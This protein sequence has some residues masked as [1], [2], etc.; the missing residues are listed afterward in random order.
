[1]NTLNATIKMGRFFVLAGLVSLSVTSCNLLPDDEDT[2]TTAPNPPTPAFSDGYATLAAVK[3]VTFQDLPGFGQVEVDFGVAVGVFFNGVDYDTYLN[4]GTVT[5]ENETLEEQD[6]GS[7]VFIPSQT[8]AT[9]IDFS[10]NPDWDVSGSADVAAFS[11]TTSIGFPSV[12]AIT[13][14]NTVSNGNDYTLTVANVSGADS[15]I[16][17]MGG[18]VHTEPGNAT[19]S[20]FTSAEI[21]GMESGATFAQAAAYKI[22]E[23]TYNTKNYWFVNEKVVTESITIE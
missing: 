17:T 18:V 1:M 9:G 23:A 21:S 14:S 20:T 6:N 2:T 11:H 19:S 3:T 22:E 8:S 4:A 13:S 5:C 15:V 7:Y 16:F 12:G 10:G